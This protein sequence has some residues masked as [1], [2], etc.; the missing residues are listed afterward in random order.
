[1]RKAQRPNE[2]DHC[3]FFVLMGWGR[4]KLFADESWTYLNEE[5]NS[6]PLSGSLTCVCVP[7]DEQRGAAMT[8]DIVTVEEYER[9]FERYLDICNKAIE[10]NKDTFPYRDI[11]KARWESLGDHKMFQCAVYDDRPKII[12]CLQLTEGMKIKILEKK[13]AALEDAWPFKYNYLKHV[14][15]NPQDYIDRPANLDWGWL[16]EI[17]G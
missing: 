14:V 3:L 11:W 15:D 7:A 17:F 8:K 4:N 6:S 9:V 2:S 10:K 12:Y 13:R 1:V 16:T 5:R